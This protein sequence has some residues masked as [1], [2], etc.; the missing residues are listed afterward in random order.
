MTRSTTRAWRLVAAVLSAALLVG[1]GAC[2][3]DSGDGAAEGTDTTAA[4]ESE[5]VDS[6]PLTVLV[7]NDDGVDGEGL[8]ALV[9]GL[10]T[11][12]AVEVLVVAPDRD[13][14]G[15]GSSST[16]GGASATPAVTRSGREATAVDGFPVDAVRWALGG[17]LDEEP[18]LV[19]SGINPGANIGPFVDISGTVGAAT[20]AA[21][22][23]VPAV[24]VSQ[25]KGDGPVDW[26]VSITYLLVWVQERRTELAGR[27]AGALLENLNV[28]TCISGTVRG[29]LEVPVQRDAQVPPGAVD[30]SAPEPATPPADDITAF[31]AGWATRSVLQVP[32]APAP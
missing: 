18:H 30:C 32:V 31:A 23:G 1:A 13:R 20:E 16:P 25:G 2:A 29:V 17:G 26:S 28:P 12:P 6:R 9:E 11:L 8:D 4:A 27:T 5:P 7:T 14:S 24:A 3:D 21:S 10:L 15:T 19:V 22:Q